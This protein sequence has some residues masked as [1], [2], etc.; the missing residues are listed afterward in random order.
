MDFTEKEKPSNGNGGHSN[1]HTQNVSEAQ[2]KSQW[3]Y[4][5]EFENAIRQAGIDLTEK[6]IADGKL[7]RFKPSG[8]GGASAWYV[9]HVY[10]GAF[11]DWKQGI[12]E[13]WGTQNSSLTPKQREQ[14]QE[15]AEKA[16]KSL[17]EESR[18][19]N[20]E[21]AE[22]AL[23][24]W[25]SFSEEGQS[26]YLTK[27]KVDALGVRFG[28]E[29]MAMPIKDVEGKLWS[30]QKIYPNGKKYLLEGGRKKGCFH[31]LGILEDQKPIYVTEG[32]ATGASV[33]MATGIATVVAIDSGNLE[34][35]VCS[36]RKKYPKSEIVIAGDDDWFRESNVGK[37]KAQE[38]AKKHSCNVIFPAFKDREQ[39]AKLED[40]E[41]PTDFNDLHCLEELEEVKKQICNVEGENN[42]ANVANTIEIFTEKDFE[43]AT[44]FATLDQ[45][46]LQTLQSKC[47][48]K[49]DQF[50]NT[51][52]IFVRDMNEE[53]QKILSS[54]Y[55]F[56]TILKLPDDP[57]SLETIP[58]FVKEA[59]ILSSKVRD[60]DQKKDRYKRRLL[61]RKSRAVSIAY[62]PDDRKIED[63]INT[64]NKSNVRTFINQAHSDLEIPSCLTEMTDANDLFKYKTRETEFLIEN[65]LPTIGVSILAGHPKSGKSW[66]ALNFI[67]T[68]LGNHSVFGEFPTKS[69]R[70][71]YL[72]LEDNTS[73]LKTRMQMIFEEDK[74]CIKNLVLKTYSEQLNDQTLED[75]KAELE[76][77]PDIKF[78]IIDPFQKVRPSPDKNS[79]AYQKDY[80]D[81][82]VLKNVAEEL[83]IS[84]L[85]VHHLKKDKNSNESDLSSL[86]GSMGLSGAA[87]SILLLKRENQHVSLKITGKDVED[88]T[89][90]LTIDPENWI[91]SL[92]ES[93]K[94]TI[95]GLQGDILRCLKNQNKPCRSKEIA[96]WIGKADDAGYSSVRNQLKSLKDKGLIESP[97]RGFYQLSNATFATSS[98]HHVASNIAL[99]RPY[100]VRD[101]GANATFATSDSSPTAKPDIS[102]S[103]MKETIL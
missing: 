78:L 24:D 33:Y 30:Y 47:F 39:Y 17:Q 11:G 23:K 86:N 66:M 18:R 1:R 45:T 36:L 100:D 89:V 48:Q 101:S 21:A 63:F 34:S 6:I 8:K 32:Y 41:K 76:N 20:Q 79:D 99:K 28:D 55:P 94:I 56:H 15:Q 58:S 71:Y 74:P 31:T 42:V 7:H 54:W 59:L 46:T 95:Q 9:C 90:A 85:L 40:K 26:P 5:Q 51:K 49:E 103:Q 44:L 3:E 72:S 19:K 25:H 52:V 84:I 16:R 87:D 81:M 92:D 60:K 2:A 77:N 88:R 82:S 70:V 69:V 68:I 37:I 83:E 96:E 61:Q 35:V 29:F 14:M 4:Q 13:K 80:K 91:F 64:L 50:F 38:A 12:K 102:P 10:A 22:T 73:R 97:K 62:L 43:N 93:E 98:N 53:I 57:A 27:K 75:L 67:K 65:V